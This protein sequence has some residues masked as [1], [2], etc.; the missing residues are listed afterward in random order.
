MENL[1]E[2]T[3]SLKRLIEVMGEIRSTSEFKI[4]EIDKNI[5]DG[6]LK[7][8]DKADENQL[9]R[10]SNFKWKY[11]NELNDEDNLKNRIVYELR[12]KKIDNIL[13]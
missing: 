8:L 11:Y 5:E 9:K 10:L 3:D 7:N 2:L 4:K 12:Y 6:I 13:E 1:E